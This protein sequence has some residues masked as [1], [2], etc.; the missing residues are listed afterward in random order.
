M[1]F[2]LNFTPPCR[3]GWWVVQLFLKSFNMQSS[4][5]V[6]FSQLCYNSFRCRR[7]G[8]TGPPRAHCLSVG[9]R[10]IAF[11]RLFGRHCSWGDK[12]FDIIFAFI[13]SPGVRA[14][15]NKLVLNTFR[16]TFKNLNLIWEVIGKYSVTWINVFY[17]HQP[18]MKTAKFQLI[19][20]LD[21]SNTVI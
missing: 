17:F 2:N 19:K 18:I 5:L 7:L 9:G 8:L 15:N 16:L 20:L 3:R 1:W 14:S 12:I 6:V 10:Y 13:F 4:F 11:T 21:S